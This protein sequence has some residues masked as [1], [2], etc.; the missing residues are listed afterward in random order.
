MKENFTFGMVKPDAVSKGVEQEIINIIKTNGF[1]IVREKRFR[2]D[3]ALAEA[4]YHVHR[5]KA[6]FSS[7]VEYITSGDVIAMILKKEN[8]IV[9]FRKLI[10]ATDPAKADPGT[11]RRLY[12]ESIERNAIHGSD[13][14]VSALFECFLV[15]PER[16][17]LLHVIS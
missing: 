7:L 11:I 3:R 8:A 1:Q 2:F 5:D 9:D 17:W 14:L 16:E 13:S 15:F 6:F 4:F 12:G 10:G